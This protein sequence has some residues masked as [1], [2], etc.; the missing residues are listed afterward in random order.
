[1]SKVWTA[2][3]VIGLGCLE[4]E[5][6]QKN[7]ERYKKYFA[8]VNNPTEKEIKRYFSRRQEDYAGSN[9]GSEM[10]ANADIE[11]SVEDK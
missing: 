7:P 9:D 4:L 11:I 10:I 2:E 3:I 5:E 1:M 6:I 8:D